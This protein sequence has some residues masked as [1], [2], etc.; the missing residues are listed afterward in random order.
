M[1]FKK[2][3]IVKIPVII[4]CDPGVDDAVALMIAIKSEK[5]DIKLITTDLGNIDCKQAAKNATNIL[6]LLGAPN[7]PIAYGEGKCFE[8]ER[9]RVAVHGK[10]GLGSY[11]FEKNSRKIE[12]D[13]AVEVM[14]KVLSE[15]EQKITMICMSP[16]TNI[17][18]LLKKYPDDVNKMEKLVFMVGSVEQLKRGEVPYA[19]FNVA[20]DPEA[21]EFILKSKVPLE[22]VPMEMGHTAYLDWQDVFKT[23]NE[24]FV[25]SVYEVMF[26]EYKDRHVK[27]GIATHDGCA[28]AYLTNPEIFKVEPV[29]VEV[30]YYEKIGTGVFVMNFDKKPNALTC[31]E[32]DVKKFKKLYFNCLKKCK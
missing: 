31:T 23:K 7:I 14:H 26:R 13:D 9:P 4:N 25:G 30:R 27:N 15:S 20:G 2:K 18:K 24:N 5:F 3:E 6:E 21:C 16:P 32:V 29:K 17:A 1:L 11:N 8:K 28:I 12:K 19:E 22:I 10:T